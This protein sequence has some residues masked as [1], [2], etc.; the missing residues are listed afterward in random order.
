MATTCHR[1]VVQRHTGRRFRPRRF[2]HSLRWFR[3]ADGLHRHGHRF[4]GVGACGEMIG[5]SGQFGC[6]TDNETCTTASGGAPQRRLPWVWMGHREYDPL[7]CRFLTR[8]PINYVALCRFRCPL[9]C[10]K[11]L[12]TQWRHLSAKSDCLAALSKFV[13]RNPYASP[14]TF[15]YHS[16]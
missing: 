6:W 1:N 12:P 13:C 5:F 11:R 16:R 8:A 2:H 10:R 4:A 7:A 9:E 3:S 15:E 14:I